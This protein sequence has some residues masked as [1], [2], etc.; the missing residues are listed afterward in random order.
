MDPLVPFQ[1][2][3]WLPGLINQA[4]T[5]LAMAGFPKFS[6]I[7]FGAGYLWLSRTD[8]CIVGCVI[9][10][11]SSIHQMP[12]ACPSCD[13]QNCLQVLPSAQNWNPLGNSDWLGDRACNLSW[14]SLSRS[15]KWPSRRHTLYT[16]FAQQGGCKM[17]TTIAFLL[18]HGQAFPETE[19]E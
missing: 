5:V 19:K 18:L 12:V 15:S 1:G 16:A 9:A 6:T 11:L 10:P 7:E 2:Q 4:S 3:P 8:L 14:S 17:G 13:N